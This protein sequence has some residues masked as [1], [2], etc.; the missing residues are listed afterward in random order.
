ML[1]VIVLGLLLV[2]VDRRRH[3][4]LDASISDIAGDQL[5]ESV[6]IIDESSTAEE[7]IVSL[8]EMPLVTD[9][10][11]TPPEL[12]VT[13]DGLAVPSELKAP[14]IGLA[15]H[16]RDEGMKQV[17]MD[18]YGATA[19]SE[20]AVA[21]ALA[22]LAKQQRTNG[23]WSLRGPYR[24]G[25][26][27]ENSAAATAMALL[28]FQG[29][30]NSHQ[31]G[32]Y[33]KQVDKG[34]RFL[35]SQQDKDGCFFQFVRGRDMSRNHWLYTQGQCTI[36][37]CELYAM[38]G[39][40]ALREPA[41]AAVNYLIKAQDPELGGWRYAPQFQSDT[42]VTGWVVMALQSALMGGLEVPTVN[43]LRVGDYLDKAANEDGSQYG[44]LA[45]GP[46]TTPM[47]A[48]ALLCRQY[49]GWRQSD[50]RLVRGVKHLLAEPNLPSWT[51]R[52]VYY[53]Y[54]A[55]QVMHHMEGEYWKTWNARMRDLLVD[56]QVT[57]GPE[58]GSW[59]PSQP[60]SD[61]WGFQGGRLYVTCL[62]IYILEVYYRHLPLYSSDALT[63]R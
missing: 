50:P 38:T 10:F 62:S 15:L 32:Q 11:A 61:R 59:H 63:A 45:G 35:L 39:D 60:E 43:L 33:Q 4:E 28:A 48:E 1:V 17:L 23:S 2:H 53:W 51:E 3:V 52:N 27:T 12:A 7:Q 41:Q 49:L 9:P 25:S 19:G 18:A 14:Q 16:G 40:S 44:Y 36:A 13:P 47:T 24:D 55:T 30:G 6:S 5:D 37:L 54:Y 56:H 26:N 31:K 21:L 46:S 20:R 29:A 34:V 8:V 57:K 22:W 42:S 58:E